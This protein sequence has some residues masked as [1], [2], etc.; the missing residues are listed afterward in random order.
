M[1]NDDLNQVFWA[2]AGFKN[3]W[4]FENNLD[5]ASGDLKSYFGQK[6]LKKVFAD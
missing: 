4:R 2:K 1:A 5:V 3:I 6:K